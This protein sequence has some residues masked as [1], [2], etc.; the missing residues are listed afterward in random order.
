MTQVIIGENEQL[1]SA[2]RRFR[3][4]VSHA[5]LFADMKKNRHF[6]TIAEK[7]KRKE[8]AR[9]RERRRFKSRGRSSR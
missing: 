7:H 5:G 2:I 4:K 8:I 3:R 6:E 9:H 1:E